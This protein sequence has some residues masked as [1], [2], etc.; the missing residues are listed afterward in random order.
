MSDG[1]VL[2]ANL[3]ES[4]DQD[5]HVTICY[6]GKVSE[7]KWNLEDLL[8][9]VMP[10]GT[11]SWGGS[12]QRA[13][14]FDTKNDGYAYVWLINSIDFTSDHEY[15]RQT[16][17]VQSDYDEYKPHITFAYSEEMNPAWYS[18]LREPFII[19]GKGYEL[20]FGDQRIKLLDESLEAASKPTPHDAAPSVSRGR[21]YPI[22][23]GVQANAQWALDKIAEGSRGAT[24][25]GRRTARILAGGGEIGPAFARKINVYFPRHKSDL[26]GGRERDENPTPGQIAWQ[27]WGGTQAWRWTDRILA[28]EEKMAAS[29]AGGTDN[30]PNTSAGGR[31]LTQR[32]RMNA[33]KRGEAMPDGSY[34]TRN[35]AE[36]IWGWTMRGLAKDRVAVEKYLRRRAKALGI[37]APD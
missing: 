35:K 21:G 37:P 6:F 8:E 13:D 15:L 32:A 9:A 14:I 7:G 12:V 36:W 16:L 20:W 27:A 30:D 22:P 25:V 3:A 17:D 33:A 19:A 31:S 1:I 28:Q 23:K 11:N 34:P 4:D 29:F 24:T 10:I 26:P 18:S 2:V 5:S